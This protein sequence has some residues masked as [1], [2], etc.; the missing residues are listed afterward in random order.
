MEWSFLFSSRVPLAFYKLLSPFYFAR[1]VIKNDDK[2]EDIKLKF[3]FKYKSWSTSPYQSINQSSLLPTTFRL[4]SPL[5]PIPTFPPSSLPPPPLGRVSGV[6]LSPS[7][8]FWNIT[9]TKLTSVNRHT[10]EI[11]SVFR[12]KAAP[13]ETKQKKTYNSQGTSSSGT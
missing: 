10:T 7:D 4:P 1:F 6:G 12:P 11:F 8:N 3:T 2:R 9:W 13:K 5:P